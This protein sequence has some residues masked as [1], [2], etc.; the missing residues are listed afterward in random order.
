[1][2]DPFRY[3][4]AA[5]V[6]DD[7]MFRAPAEAVSAWRELAEAVRAELARM[8]FP[9]TVLDRFSPAP[10]PTGARIHVNDIQPFGVTLDWHAPLQETDSYR[11]HARRQDPED[12]LVG[13]VITANELIVRSLLEVVRAAGFRTLIDHEER[14]TYHYR[15]LEA[16]RFP[17]A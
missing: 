2:T 17:K 6:A 11:E 14:Q 16:P 12:P 3:E 5:L 7:P 13:Y 4:K 1:M 8:G 10:W 15:V 9:A